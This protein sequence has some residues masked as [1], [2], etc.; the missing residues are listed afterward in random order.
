MGLCSLLA[1]ATLFFLC[2]GK[3]NMF[4]LWVLYL[5]SNQWILIVNHICRW[6]SV[7][8]IF[9]RR[10]KNTW[11]EH[12]SQYE[13]YYFL[14][15]VK[16]VTTTFVIFLFFYFFWYRYLSLLFTKGSIHAQNHSL[17]TW[18]CQKRNPW[19]QFNLAWRI[20]SRVGENWT[21]RGMN[22]PIR[23]SKVPMP[24][25]LLACSCLPFI[26]MSQPNF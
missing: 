23:S 17:F 19:S 18:R 12:T 24:K 25:I 5:R 20:S 13:K 1:C 21:V 4:K 2:N 7:K 10:K 9:I 16:N 15:I 22:S 8:K 14:F 3:Y 26:V 6:P 11:T